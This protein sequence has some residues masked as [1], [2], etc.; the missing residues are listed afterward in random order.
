[1]RMLAVFINFIRWDIVA[2]SAGL[3]FVGSLYL[4]FEFFW[5]LILSVATAFN[6]VALLSCLWLV[7][8]QRLDEA[9][10]LLS[11]MLWLLLL[12]SLY[13]VPMMFPGIALLTIWP[14]AI[15]VSY[16]SRSN[17]K[18]LMIISAVTGVLFVWI[19]IRPDSFEIMKSVPLGLIQGAIVICASSFTILT[20]LQ[21]WQYSGRLNDT[22]D[23]MKAANQALQESERNL[24]EKVSVRTQALEEKNQTLAETLQQLR[25]MQ[26]QLIVQEKLA[27]L[28]TLTAGIAHEI[29]NPL[30]F[31]NNLARLNVELIQELNEAFPE[32]A[33]EDTSF[34]L[35]DL[36]Q[37][38]TRIADHGQRATHIVQGMLQHSRSETGTRTEVDLNDLLEE[39]VHLAYHGIRANHAGFSIEIHKSLDQGLEPIMVVPQDIG[40]VFLNITTNACQALV[41]C[42]AQEPEQFGPTLWL[43]SVGHDNDVEICIRDNGPGIP[44]NIQNEIFNPFFTTKSAGEGTGLGLSISYDIIVQGHQ[45]QLSVHSEE[46]QYTEFRITLPKVRAENYSQVNLAED[47]DD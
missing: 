31:V 28:G 21:L 30:N 2:S 12:V 41:G 47:K 32:A 9:V 17:L 27:S 35:N 22:L 10:F 42:M 45:G 1:M 38:S 23:Q 7:R 37:I 6:I 3:L 11:G 5:L 36:R 4:Y 40:R 20:L 25:D 13:I 44:S 19:S 43:K 46:G 15:G 33:D 34:I 24:E 14:V 18:R 26:N 16:L 39:Y 8:Q 29:Q